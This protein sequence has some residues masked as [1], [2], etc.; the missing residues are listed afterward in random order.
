MNRVMPPTH[1]V[2]SPPQ[3]DLEQLFAEHAGRLRPML[4]R[5]IDPALAAR[6]DADDVLQEAFL[7]ARRKWDTFAQ[8]GMTPFAWL[9]RICHDRLIEHWRHETRALR[10]PAG[11]MPWPER[12]SEQFVRDLF[13]R[14][15]SPSSEAALAELRARV[16]QALDQLS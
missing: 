6:F 12:S 1:S 15:D 16:R 13:G 9:Y 3:P 4:Q 2:P 8:S 14:G 7:D 5:R 11:Y 10:D